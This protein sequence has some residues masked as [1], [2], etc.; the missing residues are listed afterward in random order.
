MLAACETAPFEDP[1]IGV[2]LGRGGV[3]EFR[4]AL[5]PGDVVSKLMFEELTPDSPGNLVPDVVLWEI[6]A[7][8]PARLEAVVAGEVP[9]GFREVVAWKG[10]ASADR[11][12]VG[13]ATTPRLGS[14]VVVFRTA[15]LRRDGVFT[16]TTPSRSAVLSDE[17][18]ERRA[19]KAC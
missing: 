13:R 16:H 9:A 18:F 14:V 2:R 19:A 3:I 6:K 10:S 8:P 4:L 5:C 7:D 15:D 1:V 12:L 17:E 11:A